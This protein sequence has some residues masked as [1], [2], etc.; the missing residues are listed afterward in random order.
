LYALLLSSGFSLPPITR[1][2]PE[3][4][5]LVLLQSLG[6][7]FYV[8]LTEMRHTVD[9]HGGLCADLV[10]RS[11]DGRVGPLEGLA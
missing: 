5:R 8:R 7:S 4:G 3:P 1:L 9:Y 2:L 11:S 10:K 6:S